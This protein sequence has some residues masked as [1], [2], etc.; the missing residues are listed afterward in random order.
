[1]TP[2]LIA[3]FCIGATVSIKSHVRSFVQESD[4]SNIAIPVSLYLLNDKKGRLS[5]PSNNMRLIIVFDKVNEIWAQAGIRFDIKYI[6][7]VTVP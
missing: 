7:R 6:V 2:L 1:M 4:I 5:S 3:L